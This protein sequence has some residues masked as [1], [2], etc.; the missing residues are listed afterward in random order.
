[1]TVTAQR[2]SIA[3]TLSVCHRS[4]RS[5]LGEFGKGGNR[6]PG[7]RPSSPLTEL[8]CIPP[9]HIINPALPFY[10]T[11]VFALNS[12]VS[13]SSK[14]IVQNEFCAFRQLQ[15]RFRFKSL[16]HVMEKRGIDELESIVKETRWNNKEAMRLF[17]NETKGLQLNEEDPQHHSSAGP[18]GSNLTWLNIHMHRVENKL[19]QISAEIVKWKQLNE[20]PANALIE[21]DVD[22]WY[23]NEKA[24]RIDLYSALKDAVTSQQVKELILIDLKI[25]YKALQKDYKKSQ[26]GNLESKAR[27]KKAQEKYQ[28]FVDKRKKRMPE[29][30]NP[31]SD[32]VKKQKVDGSSSSGAALVR[33]HYKKKCP[34]KVNIS[35]KSSDVFTVTAI[36]QHDLFTAPNG[37]G[38]ATIFP[39]ASTQ[40]LDS[41]VPPDFIRKY[42]LT[43][44]LNGP[45]PR[46]SSMESS[47]SAMSSVTSNPIDSF[48]YI[49]KSPLLKKGVLVLSSDEH[50][51]IAKGD[52]KEY[53]RQTGALV[54]NEVR[55]LFLG[56]GT[57]SGKITKFKRPYYTILYEDGDEEEMIE[58]EIL[59]WV[60]YPTE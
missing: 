47:S 22:E 29:P 9:F 34:L 28:N 14:N 50:I 11:W 30:C 5:P 4:R 17:E 56:H 25:K 1:M 24:R 48:A 51:S 35:P 13:S 59:K 37:D 55:K 44:F 18:A 45:V 60:V 33:G 7:E 43:T 19:D 36:P 10:L 21:N 40:D 49:R 42:P 16:T 3:L 2:L 26:H 46:D 54:G 6:Y 52:G 20:G 31:S 12:K 58:S 32:A 38:S 23:L 8:S 15:R 57:F 41:D 39:G 27:L 53:K